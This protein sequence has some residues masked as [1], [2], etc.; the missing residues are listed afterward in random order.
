MKKFIVKALSIVMLVCAVNPAIAVEEVGHIAPPS[1]PVYPPPANP[2][3][4]G[5]KFKE[6]RQAGDILQ[7]LNPVVVGYLSTGEKGLGHFGIQYGQSMLL[8]GVGK[9]AGKKWEYHGSQRPNN[10]A[11]NGM[12]SGHTMSAWS[13][14]AYHRTYS[15]QHREL[16]VPLYAAAIFTGAS[17]V[18]SKRHTVPQVLAA[19]VLSEMTIAINSRMDWSKT[20]AYYDGKTIFVGLNFRF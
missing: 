14:A 7:I 6:I 3:P 20:Y 12:P 10:G 16:V 11:Y 19:A 4:T 17:R 9:W 1:P 8:V 5:E 15:T 13:A 18:I 2:A